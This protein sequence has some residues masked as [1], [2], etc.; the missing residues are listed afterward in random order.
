VVILTGARSTSSPSGV[1]NGVD[2]NAFLVRRPSIDAAV[3][4]GVFFDARELPVFV[5]LPAKVSTRIIDRRHGLLSKAKVPL[6]TLTEDW[7]RKLLN[8]RAGQQ[9]DVCS[10][11][12]EQPH[13]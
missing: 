2:Q 4:I 10:R 9:G 12:Q 7:D 13:I 3:A 1:N 11:I 8:R 5:V 6:V